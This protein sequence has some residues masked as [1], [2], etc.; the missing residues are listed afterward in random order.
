MTSS[1]LQVNCLILLI[2]I[3]P[4][5]KL[6]SPGF[7]Y[8]FNALSGDPEENELMK[9]FST[10]FKAG[11]KPSLIPILKAVYPALSFLVCI[12]IFSRPFYDLIYIELQPGPN[13]A[14]RNKALAV[15]NRIG[16]GLLEQSKGD[17]SS[18]R[19]DIL[20]ILARA[21]TVEEKAHQMTDEE[22]MSRA[23]K[24]VLD[25]C[26]YPYILRD[27]YFHRRRS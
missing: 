22:V 11:Q 17:K 15:M 5:L 6:K 25:L 2:I 27:P 19:K 7:N 13:D 12:V 20:S 26:I 21:N 24:P 10:I 4:L 16:M 8:D 1:D 14:A 9:A 3:V 18:H 23:Y